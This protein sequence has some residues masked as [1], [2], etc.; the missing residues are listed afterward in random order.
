MAALDRVK[1]EVAYLRIWQ[2]IFTVSGIS[3][4]GWL[5]SAGESAAELRYGLALL[6][7][8]L[9]GF[10]SLILHRQI[11]SRIRRMETL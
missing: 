7:V 2:G 9:L 4:A 11:E 6:G 8:L 3:L 10:L 1:E 5:L